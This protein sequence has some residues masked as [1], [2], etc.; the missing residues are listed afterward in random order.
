MNGWIDNLSGWGACGSLI[1]FVTVSLFRGWAIPG[2]THKRELEAERRRGDE[3]K[4]TAMEGRAT[5][6][7]LIDNDEVVKKY[8][9]QQGQEKDPV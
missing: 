4:E 1:I 6:A 7:K 8:R 5:I 9:E 3:W 2:P